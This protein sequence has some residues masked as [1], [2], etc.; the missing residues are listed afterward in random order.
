MCSKLFVKNFIDNW[1]EITM[2]NENT[3]K[4]AYVPNS[5]IMK[6]DDKIKDWVGTAEKLLETP[7][8]WGGRNTLGIDCSALIQLSY[9]TF[10]QNIP[11]NTVDQVKVNKPIVTN[12]KE[13]KRGNVVFWDGHVALMVDK[14]NCIHAN[15]FHMKTIKEPLDE[16]I[17]R[18]KGKHEITKMIDFNS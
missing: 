2:A 18:M 15:G 8:K 13:L 6:I 3:N 17:F 10:G 1:A 5:H 11:R 4:S 14:Y 12:I 16:I 9:E 7:Y